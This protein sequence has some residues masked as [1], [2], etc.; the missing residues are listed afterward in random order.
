MRIAPAGVLTS[1]ES[2]FDE[3]ASF[4]H[5]RGGDDCRVIRGEATIEDAKP[6][7]KAGSK[8]R[9]NIANYC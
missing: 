1:Q 5:D 2:A 4:E 3:R 8:A 6:S 7:T 9:D